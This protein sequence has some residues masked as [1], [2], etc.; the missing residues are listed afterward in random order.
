MNI[1]NRSI[2]EIRYDHTEILKIGHSSN[3]L[4]QGSA[5]KYSLGV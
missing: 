4:Y 3:L 2:W 5:E 1:S